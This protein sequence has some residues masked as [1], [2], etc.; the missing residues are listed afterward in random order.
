[1]P[2]KNI[3]SSYDIMANRNPFPGLRPFS[4]SENHL[5]FGREGHSEIVLELLSKNRFVAVTGASGSGKSSLIYCGLIPVLYGGFITNA[6]SDWRI[7]TARPGNSPVENLADS[8]ALVYGT[9][10]NIP[11]QKQINYTIL[12]R[13]SFGLIDTLKQLKTN[14]KENILLIIDQFEELF[15]FKESRKDIT[16]INETEAYIKLLVNAVQQENLPVY[17]VLTMRSD[18]IGECSQF[19]ELTD[20][21]NQSNFLIPQMTRKDFEE[22]VVGP[23]SVAG[24]EIDPQLLQHILNSIENKS[25][26]LPVLQH[27][28]M[29]TWDFWARYNE[30]GSPIKMRDYESAG[31]M[32][33]ALSRHANEAF[34]ELTEEGQQICKV[35]FKSITLKGSDNKGIRHPASIKSIADI[36]GTS[37]QKVFEVVEKFR[38][39]GRSFLTPGE[40]VPLDADTVVDIS[41]ESLMRI[42]DKLKNWVDEEYSS[43]QMY[44]RLSESSSLYQ[45]GK[46]GLLRPPDLHLALNWRKTQKPTLS[47]AKK[48]YPA[49]E[50]VIVYLEASEK[51]YLQ[52]EQ[53]KVKLQRLALSR[54][55]RFALMAVSMAFM[56][57]IVAALFYVQIDHFRDLSDENAE[58]R[59][60]AEQKTLIAEQKTIENIELRKI[61]ESKAGKAEIDA[62]YAKLAA[63]SAENARKRALLESTLNEQERIIAERRADSVAQASSRARIEA[64]RTVENARRQQ[65]QAETQVETES[66]KKFLSIAQTLS[67]KA[68]DAED[69]DLKGLLALQSYKFN[70]QYNGIDNHPDVYLGLFSALK[71]FNGDNFNVYSGHNGMVGA[72]SF[73][74]GTQ[75]LYS[76]GGDG[77]ICRWDLG[78]A[79]KT[80]ITL[81]TNNFSNRSLIVSPDGRWLASATFTTGIQVFNLNT[82]GQPMLFQGHTGWVESMVFTPDSKGLYS[83]GNDKKI[84]Y[85]DLVTGQFTIFVTHNSKIRSITISPDGKYLL[86]GTELGQIVVWDTQNKEQS[87]AYTSS[88]NIINAVAYNKKGNVFVCG[89]LKGN[90][91]MFNAGSLTLTRSF[92]AHNARIVDIDFS[93]DDNLMATAGFDSKIKIW[94]VNDLEVRPIEI[95]IAE[96]WPLSLSFSPN[97]RY[98]VSSHQ[99]DKIYTW[100]TRTNIMADQIC[101][102]I[103]RNMTQREWETFVGYDLNYQKTCDNK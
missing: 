86:G 11:I 91:Y 77:K 24:A 85:W 47:W 16:T 43:V 46:T 58:Q 55:R 66:R 6:G 41:H 14:P 71:T 60:I 94:N 28:M 36:A 33:N 51:K 57:F 44:L 17:I 98:I 101:N 50:K 92:Q 95:K 80:P 21:I 87:I 63:D 65:T 31:K 68:V 79:N 2:V 37:Y 27:A 7:I 23:V 20:L 93:I 82:R 88:G 103:S 10:N 83:A 70:R 4:V 5:F 40:N 26:Q 74:P 100:P 22:A 72:I 34:E 8:L 18:F 61:A 62:L 78:S 49:F 67:V 84:L 99:N 9:D 42:W 12:R 73:V 35:L 56:A 69:P 3:Q 52:E 25:D 54:S 30:P 48:Y 89:D 29:R 1:M 45:V 64:E 75:I 32:E 96:N 53:N 13:N 97:G 102:N 19:N 15:R 81:I 38:S 39:K 76:S 90:I 59:H